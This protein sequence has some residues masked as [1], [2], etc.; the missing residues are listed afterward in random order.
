MNM[1]KTLAAIF[2]N[3]G[4]VMAA[5]FVAAIFLGIIGADITVLIAQLGIYCAIAIPI[6]GVVYVMFSLLKARETN[7]AACAIILLILLAS[8]IVWRM[9]N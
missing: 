5:I 9:L 6:I 8:M 7:F 2:K 4:L 1:E 3:C